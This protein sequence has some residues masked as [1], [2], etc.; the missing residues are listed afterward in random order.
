M[1]IALA[2][3]NYHIGDFENNVARIKSAIEKA[4]EM[5]ADVVV[6]AE[7]AVCGYPP[8]DFLEFED[9]IHKSEIGIKSIAEV[10]KGIAA[11]VGAPSVNLAS[12][13]KPLHN[14][15]YFLSEGKVLNFT[16]KT[17]LPNYDVF[18]EYRYFEPNRIDYSIAE[19]KKYRFALTICEDLWNIADDPLYVRNPMEEL[20]ELNPDV[21]IN[22]AA[23]PFHYD[24]VR[25]RKEVLTRNALKYNLPVFYVN[26]VGGQT[27]LLFD[28]GSMVISPDGEVADELNYF[29]EDLRV[30]NLNDFLY[31]STV[32]SSQF[33][34]KDTVISSEAKQFLSET[35]SKPI[36][37]N[38]K[39]QTANYKIRLIHDALVMG[40]RDYFLKMGFKKAILG[41]SGG[42]DS[43]VTLVLAARALG[44]ENVKAILL[45]SRFSSDHSI[46]DAIELAENLNVSYDVIPIEE[47]FTAFENTLK[48]FFRELPFNL[49]EENM[50]ARIRAVILMALSNKFGYI[51]LNTSNKSEAAVGYGTLY[52][53]MCGGIS[54]LGDVYKTQVNEMASYI[55]RK[56]VIIPLNTI[57]K[58]PSAELRPEQK[59]SDSLPEYEILDKILYAYIEERKGPEELIKEGFDPSEVRKVLKMVNISEYKRYQTP[60]ILRVSP[61]AF[62]TG[63]RMPIVAKYLSE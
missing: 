8:R 25:Q 14:T 26:H 11:V 3:I 59:D 1:R 7:L 54:V 33:P 60:P 42:I 40:I 13:G 46:R 56:K 41:L 53:D 48:P 36:T 12:K 16:H 55:N 24:Q 22:I 63:R 43:A 38:W 29:E 9:F 45:P 5:P 49:A 57:E 37:G 19:Y 27:E 15:V 50:Q 23:S 52:G 47:A 62:G 6:F 39:L 35:R 61:K 17:L 28:G 58:P 51:L 44:S 31:K 2:Q 10:C 20:A 21:I 32:P 18:D 34:V 30:Y 4:K